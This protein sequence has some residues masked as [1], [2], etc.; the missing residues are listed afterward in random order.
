VPSTVTPLDFKSKAQAVYDLLRER[1]L[2]GELEPGQA[3]S[4]DGLARELGVS[5]IP[6]REAIKL[7]QAERLVEVVL[8]V[9]ARVASISVEEAENIYPIR[10]VLGELAARLAAEHITSEDVDRLEA[11][12]REMWAATEAGDMRRFEPLNREFHLLVA[13]ASRNPQLAE[14]YRDLMARCSRYRAG[15]RLTQ[16]RVVEV[17]REHQ[18]ILD[19]LHARDPEAC[20]EATREHN[21]RATRDALERM[22]RIEATQRVS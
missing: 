13:R 20:V 12:H 16:E 5:K 22:R 1:I 2:T 11:L 9:G 7:L 15:V 18:A 4:I 14:L 21:L 6:I 3:L 10:R 19:A 17:M 8:H